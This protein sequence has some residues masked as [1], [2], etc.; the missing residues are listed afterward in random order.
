MAVHLA[1]TM[2]NGAMNMPAIPVR[3]SDADARHP[4]QERV[5]VLHVLG[6]E[7]VLER[8]DDEEEQALRDGVEDDDHHAH[9]DQ[10]RRRRCRRSRRSG[11]GCRSSSRRAPSWCSAR[12]PRRARRTG[13][14]AGPTNATSVP[15]AEPAIAGERRSSRKTPALTIVLEWSRAEVGDGAYMAPSSHERER[16]LGALRDAR[17]GRAARSRA[18]ARRRPDRRSGCAR[19]RPSGWPASSSDRHREARG[20]R[21]GS[22]SG[23]RKA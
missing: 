12:S 13:T 23:R 1:T 6:V 21:A 5:E 8:A 19:S 7:P 17:P 3:A 9:P 22:C 20:R 10:L 2:P 11:R 14:S 15:T 4:A 16:H 18:G